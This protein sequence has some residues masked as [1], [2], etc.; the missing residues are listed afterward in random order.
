VPALCT[1][2]K[3]NIVTTIELSYRNRR[4]AAQ[5]GLVA[6]GV[7]YAVVGV[8]AL[9]IAFSGGTGGGQASQQGALQTIAQGPF[10]AVLVGLVGIG[11]AGYAGWRASQFFTEK[12]DE[13]GRVTAW[14]T[15]AGYLVR[16]ALYAGLS[17]LALR[18][19]FG[20][21]GGGGGGSQ[22]LTARAMA[23]PGGRVLVG[24]VGLIIVGVACYQAYQAL[25]DDFMEELQT[26]QM[27]LRTRTW[28]RRIGV[29][30]HSGRAVVFGLIGGFVVLA[31][32][33]FNPQQAVGLD[34]ALQRL[35]QHTAGPWL[36]ALTALGLFAYG[37]YAIARARF[38][39]VSE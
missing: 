16:A 17:F 10:G 39:D 4:R 32:V 29:L 1:R 30:G 27:D 21:G 8:L 13:D 31:A 11:L 23:L 35:A 37:V 12:G 18:I 28:V 5:I 22:A 2:A 7:L 20:G 9:Q 38:V 14:V 19:A 15:R 36:L 6:R 3:A 34:G 25:S 33:Q 26:H 24:L